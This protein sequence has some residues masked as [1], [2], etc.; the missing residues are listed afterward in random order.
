MTSHSSQH[1]LEQCFQ[2]NPIAML[3]LDESGRI[4]RFNRALQEMIGVEPDVLLGC[5]VES[6]SHPNL[7]VL[8]DNHGRI[9]IPHTGNSGRIFQ[10][11]AAEV[12]EGSGRTLH[13]YQEISQL[14]HLEAEN[15][16]LRLQVE[17]LSITDELTGLP[18]RRLLG[19][20]LNT[21]V[22]RS[23]RYENPLCLAVVEVTS[24]KPPHRPSDNIIL[25]IS[26]FLRDRLRWADMIARWSERQF[27]L[28]L[29][30]TTMVDGQRLLHKI[31]LGFSDSLV[32]EEEE[33]PA[34][35]LHIGLAEWQKG[36]DARLLMKRAMETLEAE[37]AANAALPA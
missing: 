12:P 14:H 18:N 34:I 13:C 21:Q 16:Q 32:R 11:L 10:C 37:R 20:A 27:V 3:I 4:E 33:W 35:Q 17:E 25:A 31:R 26:R 24:T 19:Q 36:N 23:R 5:D 7:R 1:I 6:L 9:K 29:P 15:R 8:F 30:E 2:D 28:L 22:T